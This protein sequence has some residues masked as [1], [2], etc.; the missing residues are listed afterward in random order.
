ME[1]PK[2]VVVEGK[3]LDELC[4][5]YSDSSDLERKED[6]TEWGYG[7]LFVLRRVLAKRR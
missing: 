4:E 5:A 6:L 2:W 7:E 3:L 1:K